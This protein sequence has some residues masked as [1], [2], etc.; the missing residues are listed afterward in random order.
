MDRCERED[1]LSRRCKAGRLIM[2]IHHFEYNLKF[3]SVEGRCTYVSLRRPPNKDGTKR[4]ALLNDL[5]LV[6]FSLWE[7]LRKD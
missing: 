2:G 5:E 4:Y 3:K 6:R 7:T 1:G